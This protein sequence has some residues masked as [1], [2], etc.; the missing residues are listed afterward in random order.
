MYVCVCLQ[1][2][3]TITVTCWSRFGWWLQYVCIAEV[4]LQA[5]RYIMWD[6]VVCEGFHAVDWFRYSSVPYCLCL[7]PFQPL[8]IKWNANSLSEFVQIKPI[9]L[10]Y[11]CSPVNKVSIPIDS[12]SKM[13]FDPKPT[14]SSCGAT[15]LTDV[16]WYVIDYSLQNFNWAAGGLG[17][18][19]KETDLDRWRKRPNNV[20]Q[21]SPQIEQIV[22]VCTTQGLI[23]RLTYI[24]P[25]HAFKTVY[26]DLC[27]IQFIIAWYYKFGFFL[28][29]QSYNPLCSFC[30]NVC[31]IN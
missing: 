10:T 29:T 28:S 5:Y 11:I 30:L 27:G 14:N 20:H 12:L 21:A 4:V 8:Q 24:P 18:G 6:M 2:N 31:R 22:K 9:K 1:W 16:W 26:Y 3:L 25:M 15:G 19:F 17:S 23:L 13:L 7:Y